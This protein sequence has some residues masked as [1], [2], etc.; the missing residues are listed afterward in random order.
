MSK[1]FVCKIKDIDLFEGDKVLVKG[2]RRVGQYETK[3][4]RNQQGWT[5]KENKTYYNN[6][7][8]FAAIIGKISSDE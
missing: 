1:I 6:D 5:L 8:C 2:T 4:I 7:S 3:I